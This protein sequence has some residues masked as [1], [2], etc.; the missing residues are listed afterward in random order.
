MPPPRKRLASTSPTSNKTEPS[1]PPGQVEDIAPEAPCSVRD[2]FKVYH[3]GSQCFL[4]EESFPCYIK[5]DLWDILQELGFDYKNGFRC[6]ALGT[7]IHWDHEDD[8][9]K[10]LVQTGL[11]P[12]MYTVLDEQERIDD[13]K[14]WI[15]FAHVPIK[16]S[17]APKVLKKLALPSDRQALLSLQLLGF[18]VDGSTQQIYRSISQGIVE[19]F[20]SIRELRNCVRSVGTDAIL[21][22]IGSNTDETPR[23]RARRTTRK[24]DMPISENDLLALRLWAALSPDPLPGEPREPE[25]KGR[26][27]EPE[28]MDVA[29]YEGAEEIQNHDSSAAAKE[30]VYTPVNAPS[31]VKISSEECSEADSETTLTA[32]PGKGS[33]IIL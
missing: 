24:Q 9:R 29:T 6:N 23:K 2:L 18:H 3:I 10:Y 17:D 19:E 15:A 21:D 20:N 25:K 8:V 14:R 7:A 22:G 28:K 27:N 12:D 31:K 11:P 26:V 32:S 1:R 13:L 16:I 4:E 30:G 33:C 5:S